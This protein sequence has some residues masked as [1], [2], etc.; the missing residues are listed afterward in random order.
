[1]FE[2]QQ[3][4]KNIE[5]TTYVKRIQLQSNRVEVEKRPKKT[6]NYRKFF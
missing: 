5:T 1:M 3:Q 2:M 4:N 6:T